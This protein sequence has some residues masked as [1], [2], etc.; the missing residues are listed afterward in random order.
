[1]RATSAFFI[2]LVLAASSFA[3]G[4]C[5]ACEEFVGKPQANIILMLDEQNNVLEA[6]LY[7]ENLSA[8]PSRLPITDSTLLVELTNTEDL[9]ELY[10]MYTDDEGK[11][12]FD[13]TDWNASC[14][15]FRV[16]YCPFCD[17]EI[18]EEACGFL[19][20]MNYA[21]MS[22]EADVYQYSTNIS[23][24]TDIEVAP[25]ESVPATLSDERYL[26]NIAAISYCPPPETEE[27]TP[28]LCLPLLIVFSLLAGSLYMTGRNPFAAFNIGGARVGRHI[29]YQARGRGF[30]LNVM[31]VVGAARS[32]AGAIKT[33]SGEGGASALAKQEYEAGMQRGIAGLVSPG[34]ERGALVGA[35]G[36]LR[37]G[38]SKMKEARRVSGRMKAREGE[39]AAQRF[40]T[41]F[42]VLMEEKGGRAG[43]VQ[44]GR[45]GEM[46]STGGRGTSVRG[47]DLIV[48]SGARRGGGEVTWAGAALGTVA[49]IFG[50][51]LTQTMLG[52]QI[53]GFYQIATG[54]S[55]ASDW[56]ANHSE[57]LQ[58][59]QRVYN[60]MHGERGALAVRTIQLPGGGSRTATTEVISVRRTTDVNTG[61]E[62]VVTRVA[63]ASSGEVGDPADGQVE[64]VMD[65]NGRVVEVR[66]DAIVEQ[67]EGPPTPEGVYPGRT[68]QV[69]VTLDKEGNPQ[70]SVVTLSPVTEI[71]LAKGAE[72]PEGVERVII[73]EPSE[74]F[75][76]AEDQTAMLR[77]YESFITANSDLT[78]G[79]DGSS[80]VTSV[81][82]TAAT[83]GNLMDS[84]MQSQAAEARADEARARREANRTSE[85][86]AAVYSA[87]DDAAQEVL[88]PI[89]GVRPGDDDEAHR[90]LIYGVGGPGT[91]IALATTIAEETGDAFSFFGNP[92][93]P[94]GEA[95]ALA[96]E[97]TDELRPVAIA[98]KVGGGSVLTDEEKQTFL[99][100]AT[101]VL[102]G[103]PVT[104]RD[105]ETGQTTSAA[106]SLGAMS[107][108]DESSFEAHLSRAME[109]QG[110][111]EGTRTRILG[112][113]TPETVRV[114][115][116]AAG[117][118]FSGCQEANVGDGMMDSLRASSL[119]S[120]GEVRDVG[121]RIERDEVA[122]FL[123][124]RPEELSRLSDRGQAAVR[125]AMFLGPMGD[126]MTGMRASLGRG[127]GDPVDFSGARRQFG[128]L[129]EMNAGYVDAT[130]FHIAVDHNVL[131]QD[132][133]QAGTAAISELA[134]SYRM[135]RPRETEERAEQMALFAQ[136]AVSRHVAD[137]NWGAAMEQTARI[138]REARRL[139]N[140][141]AADAAAGNLAT[142]QEAR[143]KTGPFAAGEGAREIPLIW[144]DASESRQR[145]SKG[146]ML[147][148]RARDGL[149]RTAEM[150]TRRWEEKRRKEEGAP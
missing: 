14:I 17:P 128:D 132:E 124:D 38:V 4:E 59:N 25:G 70:A 43:G 12:V 1:M 129:Q 23:N 98:A 87:R 142:L 122:S 53:G 5:I 31:S 150:V 61:E 67:F 109:V 83:L 80:F 103:R 20:C 146:E 101:L 41:T 45:G 85:G 34:R 112:A 63:V 149:T 6:N 89:S 96:T 46:V 57:R 140:T 13:Y 141:A 22:T 102:S 11:A 137:G 58:D 47:E 69:S 127:P 48:R 78:V 33:A 88:A 54:R 84:T 65:T 110:V 111:D 105:E 21:S 115:S 49:N 113:V 64:V 50:Y 9:S 92:S 133:I 130:T 82:E 39:S 24:I 134:H 97:M 30:H 36:R 121:E 29:R 3:N 56:F 72:A 147:R 68:E 131:E 114:A 143:D 37:K 27:Y 135:S 126:T 7:Y 108:M 117:E 106:L 66:Y 42:E 15:N 138:M 79:S 145:V 118:F 52:Q 100:A 60:A 75:E 28:A 76:P 120:V 44:L 104:V 16:L 32:I 119:S 99:A 74:S 71:P 136:E 40:G 81:N 144:R 10:K 95:R 19:E 139:G 26:P 148:R 91:P 77:T 51:A 125:E 8:T 55:L 94:G 107:V 18:P 35:L 116:E 123:A 62:R 93:R 73:R 86:R 90:R 2:L